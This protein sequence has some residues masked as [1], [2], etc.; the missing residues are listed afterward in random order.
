MAVIINK[1]VMRV[2]LLSVCLFVFNKSNA[3]ISDTLLSERITAKD[4]LII[5][6]EYSG[7]KG[8][9]Q[10]EVRWFYDGTKINILF[11]D[12]LEIKLIPKNNLSY[13]QR[14]AA[15]KIMKK[16][17]SGWKLSAKEK[18]YVTVNINEQNSLFDF[19][20]QYLKKDTIYLETNFESAKGNLIGFEKTLKAKRSGDKSSCIAKTENCRTKV[21]MAINYE[22]R[23]YEYYSDGCDDINALIKTY[24]K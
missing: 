15:E 11:F 5:K 13:K 24:F 14:K 18:K 2:I 1:N 23:K 17:K 21:I 16:Y 9:A 22:K 8:L 7:C 3:S 4:T 19:S 10:K 6:S 12:S 20:I